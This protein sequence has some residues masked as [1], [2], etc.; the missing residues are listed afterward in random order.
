M[1]K[2]R[3]LFFDKEHFVDKAIKLSTAFPHDGK[4]IGHVDL[5]SSYCVRRTGVY[6]LP[7]VY[8]G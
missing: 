2:L 8:V 5:Y 7:N 6:Q 1:F 3:F 4:F